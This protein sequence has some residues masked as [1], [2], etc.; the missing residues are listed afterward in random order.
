VVRREDPWVSAKL[1]N[2]CHEPHE[3]RPALERTLADLGL[4]RLDLYLI[5][6]PEAQRRGMGFPS[7]P[8]EQFSLEQVALAATWAVLEKLMDQGLT[9]RIGV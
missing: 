1:W 6:W 7:S 4:D 5:H 8:E 2:D 9:R 3:V